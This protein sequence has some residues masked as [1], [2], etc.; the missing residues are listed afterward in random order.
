MDRIYDRIEVESSYVFT[1]VDHSLPNVG[2]HRILQ[3]LTPAVLASMD[4]KN[5]FR[6]PPSLI[7]FPSVQ[8]MLSS[9]FG[10]SII[11][12]S[13]MLVYL[14]FF[15]FGFIV[16]LIP[17]PSNLSCSAL[18]EIRS[19]TYRAQ[20]PTGVV[21]WNAALCIRPTVRAYFNSLNGGTNVPPLS[22]FVPPLKCVPPPI[23]C[24]GLG[25]NQWDNKFFITF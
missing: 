12:I 18:C 8:V 16:P 11:L 3:F 2:L 14:W 25:L 15:S 1:L 21:I 19:V 22:A 17:F 23:L 24:G 4:T 13:E 6:C 20:I 10:S 9:D 7:K 5:D